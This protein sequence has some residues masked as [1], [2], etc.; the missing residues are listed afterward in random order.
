MRKRLSTYWWC[1]LIGWSVCALT[2]NAFYFFMPQNLIVN[3]FNNSSSLYLTILAGIFGTHLIRLF[4]IKMKLL[5]L[6]IAWQISYIFFSS[7]LFA[8]FYTF[9][10]TWLT[11]IF[12]GEDRPL[13]LYSI[14]DQL[15]MQTY[16]HF[17]VL[18]LWNLIYF[19]Y[20]YITKS[21]RY[22]IDRMRLESDLKVQQLESAKQLAESE[23]QA[24]RSQMNPHFIFNALQSI[25]K[26]VME[27]DK[28]NASEY[29]SKF[30]KLMRLILA[31][32]REQEV[33]LD[34]DLLALELYMQ[35]ESLRFQN[36]FQY[37]IEVDPKISQ[38]N[39]LIPPLLLQ[40]FVENS[41]IH[42]IQSREG[43]I[44]TVKVDREDNM[45]RCTI[46]D[47]GIGRQQSA[48]NKLGKRNK[49]ESLGMKVTQERLHMISRVRKAKASVNVID[50]KD[51][52]NKPT[53]LKVEIMLPYEEAF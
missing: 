47:N 42:G 43:G 40:P 33:P 38:E 17:F 41:I 29:L 39:T 31:N 23:M 35:L 49:R 14:K 24:L 11:H 36:K 50:L 26:Y 48:L 5:E 45:I 51:A 22:Q 2:Y 25:N 28:Q 52:E 8:I 20:H 53:G 15:I 18:S 37:R 13:T 4:I 3:N 16:S 9:F 12:H 27:S 10:I 30:S 46:K 44:I 6:H 1:Q 34:R 21:Y 19:A 32:S 7:A